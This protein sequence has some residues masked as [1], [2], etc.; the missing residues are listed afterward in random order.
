MNY[1]VRITRTYE[2][3]QEIVVKMVN[4]CKNVV[5]Y[6][7]PADNEVK[8]THCHFLL[9]ECNV[10]TDTLKNWIKKQCGDVDKTD[11]SFKSARQTLEE[12]TTYMTYMSKGRYDPRFNNLVAP[13]VI[14]ELKGKWVNPEDVK[15][16]LKEGKLVRD[17]DDTKS[18]VSK[19]RILEDIIAEVGDS[20]TCARDVLAGI[21][22]VLTKNNCVIGQYKVLD[23]YDSY[24]MYSQ[25]DAWLDS[26]ASRIEK[27]DSRP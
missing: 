16:K 22:K 3:L 13:D 8:R 14:E 4:A 21:R 1:A 7:H 27:R 24:M 6:E 5:C 12:M 17:I 15:L 23:Y 25:K 19:R 2:Q 9:V 18:V 11:W 10:S 26:L 20:P